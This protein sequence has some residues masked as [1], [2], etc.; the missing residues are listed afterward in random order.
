M[1][2]NV[3]IIGITGVVG[4]K[5]LEL[6]ESSTIEVDNLSLYASERSRSKIFKFRGQEIKVDKFCDDIDDDIVFFAISARFAEEFAEKIKNNVGKIIDNSTAHR[7]V[8]GIP[9]VVPSVNG[10][11]IKKEDK[12]IANPNCSTIEMVLALHPI[13]KNF[14]IK[15]IITTTLQSV[16]GSGLRSINNL[17]NETK[18][19]ISDGEITSKFYP[20]PIAFN[21]LPFIGSIEK[22]NYSTEENKMW[23]ET[24]KIFNDKIDVY[25][26][27]LR[28]PT[29]YSHFESLYVETEKSFE[30]EEIEKIMSNDPYLRVLNDKDNYQFPMPISS[31]NTD[32]VD[33]GRFRRGASD[34][35]L[36]FVISADNIRI[37]AA[38]NAVRIAEYIVKNGYI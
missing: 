9:L 32:I 12:I 24:D 4:Q 22:N 1:G 7:M 18:E 8:K 37:G 3:S 19:F 28:V 35:S 25:A 16:S 38:T 27:T 26:T 6:L 29:F 34:N 13:Y 10:N 23:E 14:G 30:I 20:Y 11:I 5:M 15:K 17:Y 2:I 21:V 31:A 33:V 36:N